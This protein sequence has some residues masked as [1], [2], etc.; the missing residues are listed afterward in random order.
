LKDMSDKGISISKRIFIGF[1]LFTAIFI[2]SYIV[3]LFTR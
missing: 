3:F 1:S 2:T